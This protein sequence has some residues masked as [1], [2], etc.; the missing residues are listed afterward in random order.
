VG[1][2]EADR[3]KKK[4]DERRKAKDGE[5]D[6]EAAGGGEGDEGG[7]VVVPGFYKDALAGSDKEYKVGSLFPCFF[8]VHPLSRLSPSPRL[9]PTGLPRLP[10]VEFLAHRIYIMNA[11]AKPAETAEADK[12]KEKD[13]EKV[14][15]DEGLS[16]RAP[17]PPLRASSS[18]ETSPP[19]RSLSYMW[20]VLDEIE[21]RRGVKVRPSP[22][23]SP[24]SAPST[25]RTPFSP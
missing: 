11:L 9:S 10:Q 5:G 7:S 23:N 4:R 17:S 18:H 8:L 6:G 25:N 13:A 24:P 22:T 20:Q 21:R 19:P 15:R 1:E 14:R 12:K 3:K 16:R 2:L